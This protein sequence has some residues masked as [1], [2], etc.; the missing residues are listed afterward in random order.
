MAIM[1]LT[2]SQTLGTVET[3]NRFNYVAS[4]TPAA[5]TLSYALSR[6]FGY[7]NTTTLVASK[8]LGALQALQSATIAFK[9]IVVKDVYSVTDFY[10][11]PFIANTKGAL[12]QESLPPFAGLGMRT[13]R[14]RSDIGRGTKRFIGLT[15]EYGQNGTIT[16]PIL[17]QWQTLADKLSAPL[18]YDDEGNTITF[19]PCVVK[20]EAYTTPAGSKAYRY[21]A[22]ETEQ[23]QNIAQGILW[24]V[25]S[26][27]RSQVSR[28]W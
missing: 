2:L 5:V 1:E 12:V 10:E 24:E 14:V 6:A 23:M 21:Y 19:T 20:K 8:P 28:Q 22:T 4:G 9:N 18:T 17:A 15:E 27:V 3:I 7:T 25:Y 11:T 13:N 26:T 16:A